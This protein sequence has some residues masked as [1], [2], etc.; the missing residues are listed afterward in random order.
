[1]ALRNCC[2]PSHLTLYRPLIYDWFQLR[3]EAVFFRAVVCILSGKN[4]LLVHL[5]SGMSEIWKVLFFFFLMWNIYPIVSKCVSI[6]VTVSWRKWERKI[7]PLNCQSHEG[8][9]SGESGCLIAGE[10][11]NFCCDIQ[12][13]QWLVVPSVRIFIIYSMRGCGSK[14]F[15]LA[16]W[17]PWKGHLLSILLLACSWLFFLLPSVTWGHSCFDFKDHILTVT[18]VSI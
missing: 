4:M 2:L 13:I 6:S 18:V 8:N 1:M 3:Y 9:A 16:Q 17:Q 11:N 14:V 12:K 7:Q 10:N 5:K 15:L